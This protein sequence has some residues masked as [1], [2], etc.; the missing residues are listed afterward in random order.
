MN[1]SPEGTLF[2][3]PTND[4]SNILTV[5]A[6]VGALLRAFRM[7]VRGRHLPMPVI[8]SFDIRGQEIVVLPEGAR[9]LALQLGNILAWARTLTDVT[10][11]WWR[12]DGERLHI[13]VR[14]RTATG[15]HVRVYGGGHFSECV[16]HVQ[17]APNETAA[18]SMDA[19][20]AFLSW[21]GEDRQHGREVA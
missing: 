19:L 16:G 6:P 7:H 13:S 2:S 18:V 12:T 1:P 14:G 11:R 5:T 20:H 9:N 15:A 17:L 10:A 8:L 21:L 3:M 4:S